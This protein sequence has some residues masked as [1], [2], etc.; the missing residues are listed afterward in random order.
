MGLFAWL[1]QTLEA[2]QDGNVDIAG[3]AFKA[4]PYPF[5]ARLRAEA[6]VHRVRLP[7]GRTA[8]LITR[9][10]DVVA[11][12]RDERFVK[13][14]LNA[15]THGQ[16]A[17]QPWTPAMF[18]PLARNMLDLDPP[19]HTRLRALVVKAFTPR[20]VEL[21]RP[22]IEA[23]TG[24]LLDAALT[25]GRMD[26]IRDYALPLPTTII[27]EM[28]GI[29]AKDRHSFHRWSSV[30][31]S[32]TSSSV[33]ML[34]AIP[35]VWLFLRYIRRLIRERQAR[36]GDDLLGALVQAKEAGDHLNEDEL[37]AMIFLLLIAGH[38]T[39]VNLIGNGMLALMEHPDQMHRLR[40]EPALIRSAVEEL[41]RFYSPVETATE[42]FAREE[43]T[44]AGVTIPQGALVF[45]VIASANR[46]QRQFA[47]PDALDIAREPNRHLAFG[48]GIHFCLG[49]PLARLEAQI[50]INTLVRR[51]SDLR[52]AVAQDALRWRCGL[53][54]RGLEKLPVTFAERRNGRDAR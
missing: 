42:R 11:A 47:N 17:R 31:V 24:R 45:A 14:P 32:A 18:E 34:M 3:A 35:S 37:A 7:D 29:P 27:A 38:E 15:L 10:D 20:L 21:M 40:K 12:L 44:I 4:N 30:I 46:D 26:L 6:P 23:L 49:A 13:S 50:A 2:P 19:D 51:T 25:R 22:R 8:W 53:V 39:T 54:M 41:L 33:R 28:L 36:P 5:Y 16:M 52:L 43:V 48:L 9:Y 1:A